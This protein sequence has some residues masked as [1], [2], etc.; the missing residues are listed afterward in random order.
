MKVESPPRFTIMRLAAIKIVKALELR[1]ARGIVAAIAMMILVAVLARPAQAEYAVLQSGQRLHIA[2]YEYL[3]DTVR[4]TLPG[5]KIEIPTQFLLRIEP[6]DTFLPIPVSAP[7][8]PLPYSDLIAASAKKYGLAPELI[9][10][11]IAVESNFNPLAVSPR[12]ARGLMQ[13]MPE[14]AARFAVKNVFDPRQ[15]IDAGTRYLKELLDRYQG[16]LSLALAAYNAGPGTVQQYRNVPPY[17][18]TQAYVRM[19]T[20]KTQLA[21][22]ASARSLVQQ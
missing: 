12:T 20:Q 16:N 15:N 6:E 3:G 7:D 9:A 11:V 19:V 13:L 5:G 17:R 22:E 21:R 10:S 4:L 14:T 2:G 18:E 1:P 8:P